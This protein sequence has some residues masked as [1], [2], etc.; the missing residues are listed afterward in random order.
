MSEQVVGFDEALAIMMRTF[1]AGDLV[2]A[3][4]IG[5]QIVG[6]AP[7]FAEAHHLLGLVH[8][9]RKEP[10]AALDHLDRALSLSPTLWSAH[11]N[12]GI[13]LSHQGRYADAAESFRRALALHPHSAEIHNNLGT[14]LRGLGRLDEAVG[15]YGEAIALQPGYLEALSNLANVRHEKKDFD[16]AEEAYQQVLQED[17]GHV[18]A[19]LNLGDIYQVRGQLDEAVH[20]FRRA[21]QVN[22]Q[23]VRGHNSL[24]FTLNYLPEIEMEALFEEYQNFGRVHGLPLREEWP[25]HANDR[26]PRRRLRVG[27]VSPDFR[28]HACAFFVEP[29]LEAHDRSQV[30]IFCYAEDSHPDGV[31]ERLRGL[32]DHWVSTVGLDDAQLAG[33]IRQDRIDVL[34]DLA[35]HSGR[36][37]L[38]AFARKPAPVQV[39]WLGMGYTT[40]LAAVDYFLTERC[41]VP[42]EAERY[43]TESV[44][45]L[46]RAAYA[47]RPPVDCPPVQALPALEKGYVTFGCF[48]RP[49]RIN[50]R[51]IACWSRILHVV[52]HS[53]LILNARPFLDQTTRERFVRLFGEQGIEPDRL[54]FP[55]TQSPEETMKAYA[56]IDVALDPFP[57]NGG[58]T[59]FEGLWMGVP[60][61]SLKDRPPLGRFGES[62]LSHVG[63]ADWVA[64]TE[65]AYV[66]RAVRACGDLAGLAALRA[67]LRQNM[68]QS[69]FLDERGFAQEVEAAYRDMWHTWVKRAST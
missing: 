24:L 32:A 42:P 46:P 49:V 25:V 66:A 37:R 22:P 23:H 29:L 28:G 45:C 31:T 68:R 62:L 15:H 26:D 64:E 11:S 55:V 54:S 20:C 38:L 12:L 34:V 5:K 56:E 18:G 14:A 59:T 65:D 4:S 43:F 7:D 16:Q 69:P 21:L 35:G 30:E 6:Q 1:R 9:Q 53:Q 10:Q 17:P 57:H 51:V 41:F 50:E 33:R 27:Y 47:Y 60:I 58:T 52:P 36:N 8:F 48:C 39:T 19:L 2:Q 3:L 67:E 44:Y 61:V 63:L 40:G 13:V